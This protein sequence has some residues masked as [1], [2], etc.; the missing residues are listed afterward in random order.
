MTAST[1]R[2][3]FFCVWAANSKLAILRVRETNLTFHGTSDARPEGVEHTQVRSV[4][5]CQGRVGGRW[6]VKEKDEVEGSMVEAA[7]VRSCF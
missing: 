4:W 6:V 5:M 7:M 1:S 2:F 3:G